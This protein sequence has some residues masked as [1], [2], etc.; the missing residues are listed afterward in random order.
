MRKHEKR[1]INERAELLE[2][3]KNLNSF[4]WGSQSDQLSRVDRNLLVRQ[5]EV[6]RDYESILRK[7]IGFFDL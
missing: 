7:R 4:L 5:L 3:I 6:M 2:K 1:V